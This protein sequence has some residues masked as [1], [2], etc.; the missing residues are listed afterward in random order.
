[1][2]IQG[3]QGRPATPT[4]TEKVCPRCGAVVEVFSTDTQ[5]VCDSCGQVVYNDALSCA[6]WCRYARQCLGE[7]AYHRLMAVAES[8]RRRNAQSNREEES[9]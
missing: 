3:C 2:L 5:A 4:L 7:T 1:M 9:T 8:Q 6:Q